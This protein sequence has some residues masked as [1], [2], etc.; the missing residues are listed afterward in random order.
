[1]SIKPK[2]PTLASEG[3]RREAGEPKEVDLLEM[4]AFL[5]ETVEPAVRNFETQISDFFGEQRGGR[6]TDPRTLRYERKMRENWI[7]G[8]KPLAFFTELLLR[9]PD[10]RALMIIPGWSDN[11][12][13]VYSE[14]EE[15]RIC[16]INPKRKDIFKAVVGKD[17]VAMR[18]LTP[19]ERRT[20]LFVLIIQI[21]KGAGLS[22]DSKMGDPALTRTEEDE[23]QTRSIKI[24]TQKIVKDPTTAEG[25]RV[26]NF[27]GVDIK[28]SFVQDPDEPR[29]NL[30]YTFPSENLRAYIKN[31]GQAGVVIKRDSFDKAVQ[32]LKAIAG[33]QNG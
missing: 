21:M 2:D 26:E 6:P 22:R 3:L 1:M 20:P 7:N 12:R 32:C 16:L 24:Y 27:L 8:M 15:T 5:E 18:K 4:M 11:K 9:K 19:E 30:E 23:A 17:Q 13:N 25:F 28:E 33:N 31:L 10:R 14:I 29:Y